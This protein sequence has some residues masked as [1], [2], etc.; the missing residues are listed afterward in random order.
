MGIKD[1][2]PREDIEHVCTGAELARASKDLDRSL[3]EEL[4]ERAGPA[5]TGSSWWARAACCLA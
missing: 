4:V 3:A 1:E 2:S 5:G